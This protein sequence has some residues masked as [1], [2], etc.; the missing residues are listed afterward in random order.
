MRENYR[1][2]AIWEEKACYSRAVKKANIIEIAGTT[3]IR[4]GQ[5]VCKGDIEGQ[6][7]VIFQ[8]MERT[9]AHFKASLK[10]VVR[11]RMFIRHAQDWE[12][13]TRVHARFFRDIDPVTTLIAGVQFVDDEM[14]V[15]IEATA[16]IEH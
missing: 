5:L 10:D 14:L 16:I 4:D 2:G 15:E 9:L 8:I 13:V 3:A 7:I 11:T 1:T 12:K 6:A